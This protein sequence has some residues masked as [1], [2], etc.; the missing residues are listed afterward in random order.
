[1]GTGYPA[2]V[3]A[4]CPLHLIQACRV[5]VKHE[6]D[7]Q[8]ALQDVPVINHLLACCKQHL[9]SIPIDPIVHEFDLRLHHVSAC[10][11][12]PR[13][14][15]LQLANRLKTSLQ[16]SMTSCEVR[17]FHV[18]KKKKNKKESTGLLFPVDS[19][20]QQGLLFPHCRQRSTWNY[21]QTLRNP[22][23]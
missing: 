3:E 2:N 19:R 8:H 15:D 18:I 11:H 1:M 12:H 6:I 5:A 4:C 21:F 14:V 10:L 17:H 13:F 7:K 16:G 23:V 20:R 22:R 9:E